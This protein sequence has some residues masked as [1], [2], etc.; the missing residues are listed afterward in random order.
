MARRQYNLYFSVHFALFWK[1][2]DTVEN[3]TANDLSFVSLPQNRDPFS[4]YLLR[5]NVQLGMMMLW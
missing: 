1:G 2:L 3:A 4:V 5:I